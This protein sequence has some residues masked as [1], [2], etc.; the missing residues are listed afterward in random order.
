MTTCLNN[1][2]NPWNKLLKGL[3]LL[4]IIFL[5]LRVV[6]HILQEK[7]QEYYWKGKFEGFSE[8]W[9]ARTDTLRQD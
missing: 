9:D 7:Q 5:S 8:G 4:I 6:Y 1:A 3:L 2:P